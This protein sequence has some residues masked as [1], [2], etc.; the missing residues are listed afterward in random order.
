VSPNLW[1]RG[2]CAPPQAHPLGS[3]RS[4]GGLYCLIKLRSSGLPRVGDLF[5]GTLS[6]SGSSSPRP[7]LGATA[8]L[9]GA[10]EEAGAGGGV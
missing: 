9:Q 1:S 6:P 3:R 8:H 2:S 10:G 5:P 7:G 4:G